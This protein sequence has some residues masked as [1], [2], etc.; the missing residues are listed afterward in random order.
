MVTNSQRRERERE[1]KRAKTD[2]QDTGTSGGGSQKK[3]V[4]KKEPR[5]NIMQH[6][7]VHTLQALVVSGKIKNVD[8]ALLALMLKKLPGEVTVKPT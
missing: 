4:A 5:L 8:P 6:G 2:N 1:R 3:D 7:L